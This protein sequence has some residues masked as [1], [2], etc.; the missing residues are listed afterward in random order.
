[1]HHNNIGMLPES[2]FVITACWDKYLTKINTRYAQQTGMSRCS[3]SMHAQNNNSSC[4]P[5]MTVSAFSK[6][7]ISSLALAHGGIYEG[8]HLT[9]EQERAGSV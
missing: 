8:G 5:K 6:I 2:C 1:M 9:D 7:E 4:K 3:T